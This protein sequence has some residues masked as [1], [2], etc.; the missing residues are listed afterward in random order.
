MLKPLQNS[1]LGRRK[2][3]DLTSEISRYHFSFNE[4]PNKD[5]RCIFDI[6][7]ENSNVT[8]NFDRLHLSIWSNDYLEL[9]VSL[10]K[11]F[12]VVPVARCW[13]EAARRDPNEAFSRFFFA[14]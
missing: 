10:L 8:L 13:H 3:F 12:W 5:E 6:L 7:F 9:M 2:L 1:P 4:T 14:S 11:S